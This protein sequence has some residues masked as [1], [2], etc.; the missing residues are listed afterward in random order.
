M[1]IRM[2]GQQVDSGDP[3]S[4]LLAYYPDLTCL[5][6]CIRYFFKLLDIMGSSDMD[7]RREPLGR[8]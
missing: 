1:A 3:G 2:S 7:L 5:P 4:C 8:E 6:Q